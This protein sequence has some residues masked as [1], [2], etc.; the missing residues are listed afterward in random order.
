MLF[1]TLL[2]VTSKNLPALNPILDKAALF[3]FP[4]VPHEKLPKSFDG[5][6]DLIKELFHLPFPI[7]A[8]EDPA[9]IVILIDNQPNQLGLSTERLFVEI[10][11]LLFEGRNYREAFASESQLTNEQQAKQSIINRYGKEAKNIVHITFGGIDQI[12]F[13]DDRHTLDCHGFISETALVG[14]NKVYFKHNQTELINHFGEEIS[15][16]ICHSALKNTIT[17]VQELLYFD[18]PNNFILEE[19]PIEVKPL[20]DNQKVN[21]KLRF[22]CTDN[23]IKYTILSPNEIRT[24]LGLIK[25]EGQRNSPVPHERRSHYRTLNSDFFSKKKGQTIVVKATWIGESEKVVGNK[26]Y[27]VLLDK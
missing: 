17:A 8:V 27:R 7:T 21:K 11:P 19:S 6:I 20:K 23:R 16:T 18:S 2:K 22:Q 26:R 15:K 10:V 3:H 14:K 5:D 13:H 24:K 25:P 12:D 1:D 4:Y 9:G